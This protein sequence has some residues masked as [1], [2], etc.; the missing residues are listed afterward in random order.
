MVRGQVDRVLGAVASDRPECQLSSRLTPVE[1]TITVAPPEAAQEGDPRVDWRLDR[2]A[3][4]CRPSPRCA[5]QF[6]VV[7]SSR[8]RYQP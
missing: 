2:A 3:H 8:R 1:L 6:G 4:G 7:N 5:T